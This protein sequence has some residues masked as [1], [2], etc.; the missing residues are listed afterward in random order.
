MSENEARA[1]AASAE[2]AEL[3]GRYEEALAARN[4]AILGMYSADG[5]EP[6]E[7]GRRLGLSRSG[8]WAAIRLAKGAP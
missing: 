4:R 1:R 6:A 7:V 2:A 3:Y 5:L 8:V